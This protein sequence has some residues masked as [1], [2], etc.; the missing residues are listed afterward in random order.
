MR[1]SR[2]CSTSITGELV[3][4]APAVLEVPRVSPAI[5]VFISPSGDSEVCSALTDTMLRGWN[6]PWSAESVSTSWSRAVH[7]VLGKI[8]VHFMAP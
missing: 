3:R 5:C 6:F 2:T 1:G 7:N 4:N 8:Y